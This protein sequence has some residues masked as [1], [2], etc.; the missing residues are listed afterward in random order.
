VSSLLTG[1]KVGENVKT[2]SDS[3]QKSQ[4]VTAGG[5][6][7]VITVQ[8]EYVPT[9]TDFEFTKVWKDIGENITSWCAPIT[10]TLYQEKH[11]G[12]G[13][14]TA[15]ANSR[16]VVVDPFPSEEVEEGEEPERP[17]IKFTLDGVEYDCEVSVDE[18]GVLYQESIQQHI[19]DILEGG[20][21]A[22]RHREQKYRIN[23]LCHG[24]YRHL[25]LR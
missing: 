18:E 25:L 5:T 12:E 21:D 2:V 16:Q 6:V 11:N 19:C 15:V 23:A 3:D 4:T 24:I 14:Y 22:F 8:N 9:V 7:S 10:V 17:E 13:E 20:R 1:Y